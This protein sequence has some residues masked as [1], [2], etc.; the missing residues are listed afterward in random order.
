L[1]PYIYFFLKS[2]SSSPSKTKHPNIPYVPY[3][4]PA[5]FFIGQGLTDIEKGIDDTPTKLGCLTDFLAKCSYI[6]LK[7]EKEIQKKNWEDINLT[8]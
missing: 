3:L 5:F 7:K 6:L 4:F 2:K 1:R 8:Q